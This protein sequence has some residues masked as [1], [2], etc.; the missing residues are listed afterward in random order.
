MGFVAREVSDV[1]IDG[2]VE[3]LVEPTPRFELAPLSETNQ[4][5]WILR[6]V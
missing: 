6:T 1:S 2:S 4:R 5:L 3:L